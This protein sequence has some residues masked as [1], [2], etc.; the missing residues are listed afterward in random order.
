MIQH[1]PLAPAS[2][3]PL[4]EGRTFK[5]CGTGIAV[6]RTREGR[7]FATQAQCPHRNGPLSDG[8]VGETTLICPLHEWSF[9]LSTGMALTGSCGVRV[10]PVAERADG[11]LIVEMGDDG[12]PPPFRHTDYS[13]EKP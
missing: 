10:Y 13:K 2:Q 9:D 7:V 11:T 3:I 5:V 8:L 12:S 4:G 1:I 6:F